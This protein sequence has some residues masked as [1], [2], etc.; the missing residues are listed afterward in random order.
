MVLQSLLPLVPPFCPPP[1]PPPQVVPHPLPHRRRQ[2]AAGGRHRVLRL[3]GHP[4]CGGAVG[5]RHAAAAHGDSAH[6]AKLQGGAGRGQ[7]IENM[8]PCVLRHGSVFTG[9]RMC[10]CTSRWLCPAPRARRAW[11]VRPMA[12]LC[13]PHYTC[14]LLT[15]CAL[16]PFSAPSAPPTGTG[17]PSSSCCQR[18][19]GGARGGQGMSREG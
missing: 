10:V 1:V 7:H 18:V 5:P 4:P 19:G 13:E 11:L 12:C 6:A 16:L 14:R 8:E 2:G 17:S 3:R 15:P 9:G